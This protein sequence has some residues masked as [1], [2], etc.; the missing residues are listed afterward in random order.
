M[1][2]IKF[3]FQ[4][5][6]KILLNLGYENRDDFELLYEIFI[7]ALEANQGVEDANLFN[8]QIVFNPIILILYLINEHDYFLAIKKNLT[9]EI[10]NKR[11]SYIQMLVS[12]I[13]DKYYTNEHLAF[14]SGTSLTRFSPTI[15]TL[16]LYLNFVQGVLSRLQQ[17]TPKTTLIIDMLVK[18][19]AQMKAIIDLLINGFETEAFST[20]RTLHENECVLRILTE[21]ENE[22]VP[23]YIEHMK[24]AVAFRGGL[25]NEEKTDEV[26]VE[27]KAKMR[28]FGLKSKDMKRFIEY[29]WL[30][31]LGNKLPSDFKLNFRD[32][33]QKLVGLSEKAKIYE[34]SS[35]VIHSSPLLIY[36]SKEYFRHITLIQLYET[37]FN[38]EKIF[39]KLYINIVKDEDKNRFLMMQKIYFVQLTNLHNLEKISLNNLRKKIKSKTKAN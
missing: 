31:S 23:S 36:S 8:R 16:L 17:K 27:I 22:L 3:D 5:F 37:F 21:Y 39:S 6:K 29:G 19:F 30:Y 11:E 25:F 4:Q 38:I 12:T 35:E 13:L 34:M 28:D 9:E 10:Q 26:F 24:Y 2:T 32:G 18:S 7:Y 15:S 20:W 14:K 33:V 1:S